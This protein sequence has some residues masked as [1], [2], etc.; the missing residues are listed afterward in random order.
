MTVSLTIDQGVATVTLDRAALDRSMRA[1]F[2]RLFEQ[3]QDDVSGGGDA[4]ATS[5]ALVTASL[6][7]GKRTA[8]YMGQ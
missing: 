8:Q 5:S 6:L 1:A 3:V 2:P 7:L 4:L